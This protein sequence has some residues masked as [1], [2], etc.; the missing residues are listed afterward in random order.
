MVTGPASITAMHP[1]FN[2]GNGVRHPGGVLKRR[3]R[4]GKRARLLT[5]RSGFDSPAAYALAPLEERDNSPDPQSG[6]C[7]FEPGTEHAKAPSSM[8]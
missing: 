5:G 1:T 8:G 7:R 2:R 4:N 6:D 3:W